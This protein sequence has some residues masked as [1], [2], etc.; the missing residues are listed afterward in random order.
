MEQYLLHQHIHYG[1]PRRREGA[2]FKNK[3]F[4]TIQNYYR[5]W[6]Q[7]SNSKEDKRKKKNKT[8]MPKHIYTQTSG[9]WKK[10]TWKHRER[11]DSLHKELKSQMLV[12][13]MIRTRCWKDI[14]PLYE[15]TFNE[16]KQ[17]KHKELL[18][19]PLHRLTPEGVPWFKVDLCTSKD[20]D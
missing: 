8:P 3:S 20:P 5:V 19:C 15:Q 4:Q 6:V 10:D 7:M 16:E 18:P 11:S 13:S 17:E 12:G 14:G 9:R 2:L 1:N